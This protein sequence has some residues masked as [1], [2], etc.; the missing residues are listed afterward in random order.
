MSTKREFV[1]R[2]RNMQE[3]AKELGADHVVYQTIEDMVT[4]V[5]SVGPERQ[6]CKACFD[7]HYPTG[8]ITER[9]LSDIENDR[10]E[11]TKA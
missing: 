3:I 9:M 8:D 6:F 5:Q 7:G 11:A 10:L 4:A 2:G 1:A